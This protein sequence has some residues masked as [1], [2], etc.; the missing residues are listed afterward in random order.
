MITNEDFCISTNVS[1]EP[2]ISTEYGTTI[3]KEFIPLYSVAP[4]GGHYADMA[5]MEGQSFG[6]DFLYS[7][8]I[9]QL[10]TRYVANSYKDVYHFL[11]A[12]N[13]PTSYHFVKD[14]VPH[15]IQVM[16]GL[17]Y[18]FKDKEILLFVTIRKGVR[19]S[20][21]KTSDIKVYI[22]NSLV[23]EEKYV[24]FY[25]K[26][27]KDYILKM[28]QAEIE[29]VFTSTDLYEKFFD[30]GISIE[31]KTSTELK[32]KLK[33]AVSDLHFD[34]HSRLADVALERGLITDNYEVRDR[35]MFITDRAED[36]DILNAMR[37]HFSN[38]PSNTEVLSHHYLVE[39]EEDEYDEEIELEEEDDTHEES[40]AENL[41]RSYQ[42][43]IVNTTS[44]TT[45]DI[46]VSSLDRADFIS[47][48]LNTIDVSHLESGDVYTAPEPTTISDTFEFDVDDVADTIE[49]EPAEGPG[50]D[51][52]SIDRPGEVPEASYGD[53]GG[54]VEIL[55]EDLEMESLAAEMEE[56]MDN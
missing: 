37:G 25:R 43:G 24:V 54:D 31:H 12:V 56:G 44:S 16:R 19:P 45:S 26:F 28:Q 32:E 5:I 13:I 27:Y 51:I 2:N 30:V 10:E 22:S 7:F 36:A 48:S 42:E 4:Y 47:P 29:T 49:P 14:E 8:P 38:E 55:A 41:F 35:H 20:E 15:A 9:K 40:R 1:R 52:D 11:N 50:F 6:N 21:A 34:F 23:K 17:M 18:S 3:S 33:L 53:E 46:D 39:E